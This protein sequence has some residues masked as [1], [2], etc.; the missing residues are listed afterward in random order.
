LVVP[1]FI[2]FGVDIIRFLIDLGTAYS[3]F[4]VV[5][6]TLNLEAGFGGVPN[7]GKVM[8]VAAGAVI[9]GSVSGRLAAIILGVNTHGNYNA[10]I[11]QIIPQVDSALANNAI[12]SIE[13]LFLGILLAAIIGAAFGF[14][15]SGPAVR[16]REDYLGMFLLAAAQLFQV[17]LGGYEP[18]IGGTQ[19][20]EVPDVFAWAGNGIEVRDVV[21]LGFLAIFAAMVFLYVEKVARSP[22]GRT[23]RA[24]RDNEVASRAMG[25][26]DVAI[27]RNVI[28][29]ASAISG[30]A[31][32]LLTFYAGGVTA[33]TWTRITWTFYIWVM[34]II[35]GAANNAGV[36]LGAFSFTFLF[37]VA[38][39]VK[40][41]FSGYLPFDV[42]WLEYLMF[43][44][45][46]ILI[47]VFR[48]GGILPEKSSATLPWRTVAEIMRPKSRTEATSAEQRDASAL[49][50]VI[51]VDLSTD[52]ERQ[53]TGVGD[54]S[55][56][57]P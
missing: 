27:R 53:R 37:K 33:D 42:N 23:L 54:E 15:A 2:L 47:L 35:G 31:G 34:L 1:T 26:N 22:L 51:G 24:V 16:L 5:S 17:F 8:F 14:F 21:V 10:F 52:Q 7:F 40:F 57:P 25:K 12:L 45:L 36:A 48:P 43:A 32:A 6:L 19:G 55:G 11:A 20:I 18:L 44:S 41:Y 30:M 9:A 29:V 4:L 50:G 49:P 39:Q 13:L 3:L 28:I 38:D 46:L 56:A